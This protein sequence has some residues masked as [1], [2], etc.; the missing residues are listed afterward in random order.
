MAKLDV[1][2]LEDQALV[3]KLEELRHSLVKGRFA[4]A[5]NRLENTASLRVV[6][7]DIARAEGELRRRELA[8]GLGKGSLKSSH[9]TKG[10]RGGASVEAAAGG[11]L[12]GM[13]DD[14][15]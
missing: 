11:F 8:A 1:K 2:A 4:L 9:R 13:L 15:Q 10:I 6:R 12:A 3:A 14:K 5:M 7:Q